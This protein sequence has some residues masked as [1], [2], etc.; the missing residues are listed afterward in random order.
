NNKAII[1]N[2]EKISDNPNGG[3]GKGIFTSAIGKMKNLDVLDG[4]TFD[5]QSSF[6]YQSVSTDSQVISFDDVKKNF[7]F[8]QLFSLI[9][10][11]ISLEYKGKDAIKLS[12]EES[13]KIMISTNYTIDSRGGSF[14][15]RMFE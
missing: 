3:S 1:L 13:P 9:T 6:P 5:P 11:G 2:D 7:K 15:R 4:K 10:E 8:E 14:E 12:V